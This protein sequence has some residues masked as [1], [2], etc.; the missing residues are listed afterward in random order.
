MQS[1][2]VETY[3]PFKYS[4]G[5]LLYLSFLREPPLRVWAPLRVFGFRRSS[6]DNFSCVGPDFL[7]SFLDWLPEDSGLGATRGLLFGPIGAGCAAP[8]SPSS[9]PA[10][11]GGV[12]LMASLP[13]VSVIGMSS[14]SPA[15]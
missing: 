1:L 9:T 13:L 6:F 4:S 2:F 7:S 15:S 5:G 10:L 11:S 8:S 14:M 3:S 12:S